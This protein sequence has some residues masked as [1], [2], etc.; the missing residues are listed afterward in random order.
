MLFTS[1]PFRG[2]IRF[3]QGE[4]PPNT[5]R[6]QNNT[7]DDD[8]NDQEVEEEN[9]DNNITLTITTSTTRPRKLF[10][11]MFLLRRTEP[12][13]RPRAVVAKEAATHTTQ[14][15]GGRGRLRM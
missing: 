4:T 5:L 15:G 12:R 1:F 13:L 6:L 3:N 8:D 11:R 2:S 10:A 14:R 7:Y 9:S